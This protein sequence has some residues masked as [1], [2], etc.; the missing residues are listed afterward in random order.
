MAVKH[1]HEQCQM[2]VKAIRKLVEKAY[3]VEDKVIRHHQLE[4]ALQLCDQLLR[5]PTK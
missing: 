1:T 4:S 3:V 2:C 5:E